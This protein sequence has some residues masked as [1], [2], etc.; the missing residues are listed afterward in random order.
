MCLQTRSH[1]L[2]SISLLF[3]QKITH[4][5][6]KWNTHSICKQPN[7]PNSVQGIS[8]RLYHFPGPDIQNY[9]LSIH[10]PTLDQL[11]HDVAD[12][13]ESATFLLVNKT[14][15]QQMLYS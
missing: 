2:Q 3:G 4:Y 8:Y 7:R 6:D 10:A 9:G 5:V 13:S 11:Y 15:V 1:F 12:Y 14:K